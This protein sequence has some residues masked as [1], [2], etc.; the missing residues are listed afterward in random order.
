MAQNDCSQ[1]RTYYRK[2]EDIPCDG[3]VRADRSQSGRAVTELGPQKNGEMRLYYR[4]PEVFGSGHS[5]GR[6]Y[7]VLRA[8]FNSA[9]P[10]LVSAWE[11]KIFDCSL[12]ENPDLQVINPKI[13]HA[14]ALF[15]TRAGRTWSAG[16]RMP[17]PCSVPAAGTGQRAG[18]RHHQ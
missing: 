4:E 2:A 8:F 11:L 1:P 10:K 18:L 3:A 9:N 6:K 14:D 16:T 12:F 5:F 7:H 13:Q 15:N 17:G